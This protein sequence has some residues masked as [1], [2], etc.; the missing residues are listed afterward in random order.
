MMLGQYF[1]NIWIISESVWIWM[2]CPAC[3][4]TLCWS[5]LREIYWANMALHHNNLVKE[6]L[7]CF[8]FYVIISEIFQ[9]KLLFTKADWANFKFYRNS[10][11]H[12]N[13]AA[14]LVKS[15]N[16]GLEN[17]ESVWRTWVTWRTWKTWTRWKTW[18]CSP[19]LRLRFSLVLQLYLLYFHTLFTALIRRLK[20]SWHARLENIIL[21]QLRIGEQ[22]MTSAA[23]LL[24]ISWWYIILR[25]T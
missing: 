3:T 15:C 9:Q 1:D 2:D 18:R 7:P 12:Y 21:G 20:K 5:L 17:M 14:E 19:V 16:P 4:K 13:R 10:Q 23:L 24:K 11:E 6:F 8:P 25:H 22:Q